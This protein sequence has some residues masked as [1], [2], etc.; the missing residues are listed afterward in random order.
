M[1]RLTDFHRQQRVLAVYDEVDVERV[2][3]E[4]SSRGAWRGRRRARAAGD[5]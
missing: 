4:M 3:P 2:Q 1:S 5:E